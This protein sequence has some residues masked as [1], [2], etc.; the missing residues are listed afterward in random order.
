MAKI[1]S[2]KN[3]EKL[4]GGGEECELSQLSDDSYAQP[5]QFVVKCKYKKTDEESHGRIKRQRGIVRHYYCV[6]C[7]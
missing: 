7:E 4:Y 6:R 5:P 2:P 3:V 1:A